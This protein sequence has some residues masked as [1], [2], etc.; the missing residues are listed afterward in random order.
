MKK[1]LFSVALLLLASFAINVYATTDNEDDEIVNIEPYTPFSANGENYD[2]G[3]GGVKV[4]LCPG[5]GEKCTVTL[6]VNGHSYSYVG[7]KYIG[8]PDIKVE[9]L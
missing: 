6:V 2:S 5:A 8:G 9:L 3:P 1:I 4:T 7:T